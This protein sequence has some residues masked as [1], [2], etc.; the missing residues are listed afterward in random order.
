MW[1]FSTLN[2]SQFQICAMGHSTY[3]L[4]KVV[5][6]QLITNITSMVCKRCTVAMFERYVPNIYTS[7]FQ[8]SSP[9]SSILH[10]W[11][12]PIEFTP[13]FPRS[14]KSSHTRSHV[15]WQVPMNVPICVPGATND[16]PIHVLTLNFGQSVHVVQF[17]DSQKSHNV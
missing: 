9:F 5:L 3:V 2:S 11:T 7:W 17:W 14:Q 6:W 13:T 8:R 15:L 16:V 1:G 10:V 12:F 4:C